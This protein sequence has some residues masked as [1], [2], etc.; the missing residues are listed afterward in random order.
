M[1]RGAETGRLSGPKAV[2]TACC[3]ISDTP[4]VASSVS[5]GRPYRKRMTVRSMPTPIA[6]ATRKA[7]GTA[8]GSDASDHAG[9]WAATRSC[10]R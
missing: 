1:K 6:P 3:R 9:A 7:A 10:S 4:Q 5:S 2:R 8:M